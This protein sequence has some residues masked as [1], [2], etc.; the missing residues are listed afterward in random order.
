MHFARAKNNSGGLFPDS[1][2]AVVVHQNG[3]IVLV[4]DEAIRISGAP[5]SSE[6]VGRPILDLVHPDFREYVADRIRQV[7][8]SLEKIAHLTDEK[9]IRFDGTMVDVE[10]MA[11]A[12]WHE[13]KP[14]VLVMFRDITAKKKADEALQ[15]S[16]SRLR[17]TQAIPRFIEFTR[18]TRSLVF[19]PLPGLTSTRSSGKQGKT[20]SGPWETVITPGFLPGRCSNVYFTTSLIMRY[21]MA[22]G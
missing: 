10:V 9:L 13:G 12:T 16:E 4:N 5:S 15:A 21:V 18:T 6:L 2:D 17:L 3:Q 1:F 11:T 19:I 22:N 8:K 14:A 7:L 20:W